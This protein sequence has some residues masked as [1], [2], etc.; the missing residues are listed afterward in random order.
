MANTG[1]RNLGD[2]SGGKGV[3]IRFTPDQIEAVEDLVYRY[4]RELRS[5]A[6]GIRALI[7]RPVW[8][9]KRDLDRAAKAFRGDFNIDPGAR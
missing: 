3:S 9:A 4:P 2:K 8:V 1:S 6:D 5:F 7:V